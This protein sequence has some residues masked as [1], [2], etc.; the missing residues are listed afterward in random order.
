MKKICMKR[1]FTLIEMLIAMSLLSVIMYVMVVLLEQ[2]NRA[3]SGSTAKM[4]VCEDARLL[5]D[6][7]QNDITNMDPTTCHST[8]GDTTKTIGEM[9][10]SGGNGLRIYTSRPLDADV[11]FCKVE[12]SKS[13]KLLKETVT[14]YDRQKLDSEGVPSVAK[15]VETTL[16]YNVEA[17]S[18]T[19]NDST[20]IMIISLQ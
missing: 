1:S 3:A 15:T 5:L 7:I 13:G 17:F 10:G 20:G 19:Y 2:T 8:F 12:Y 16:L 18:A 14:F 11:T 6:R 9:A 4:K